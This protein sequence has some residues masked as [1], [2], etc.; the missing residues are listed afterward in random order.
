LRKATDIVSLKLIE[1]FLTL[2][3]ICNL[4]MEL[5]SVLPGDGEGYK[6]PN[7]TYNYQ[8]FAYDANF[9]FCKKFFHQIIYP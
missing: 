2:L 6:Y 5:V 9:S 1:R 8:A 4:L 3:N 7:Q